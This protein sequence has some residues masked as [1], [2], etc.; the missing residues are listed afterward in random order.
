VLGI[1]ASSLLALKF[2]AVALALL[3]T[4]VAVTGVV[5]F[6]PLYRKL[7]LTRRS[8]DRTRQRDRIVPRR[9]R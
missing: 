2:I 3:G 8:L 6:C 1:G 5:G 7:G 9:G 4:D